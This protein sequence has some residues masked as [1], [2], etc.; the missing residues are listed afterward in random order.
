VAALLALAAV[1]FV[2]FAKPF[3]T[4]TKLVP[5]V[6]G[7]R[8]TRATTML[9]KSGFKVKTHAVQSNV[10]PGFVVSQDPK[11]RTETDEGST[12]DLGV[13]SGPGVGVVPD[14]SNL[15]LKQAIQTLNDNGF[16]VTQ[17]TQHSQTVPKGTAIRTSPKSGTTLPKGTDVRLFVSSGPQKVVVPPV[18]GQDANVARVRLESAGFKVVDQLAT[19]TAPKGRVTAQDPGGNTSADKGSLVTITVSKG[20]EKVA[21]PDEFNQTRAAATADLKSL[22]FKVKVVDQESTQPKGTVVRQNPTAGTKA[23]KGST[24]TIF[25]AIPPA[26][27]GGTGPGSTTTTPGTPT[28]PNVP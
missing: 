8:A 1:A 14:V 12:V 27:T 25:V 15:P 4:S 28:T 16:K 3:S 23:V 26:G 5:K 17:D 21:V 6:V 2:V 10:K 9:Q 24:V 7:E 18:V 20:P 11:P 19:S 13:S 22:G